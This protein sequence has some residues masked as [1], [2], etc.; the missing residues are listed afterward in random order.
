VSDADRAASE[1]DHRPDTAARSDDPLLKRLRDGRWVAR[2]IRHDFCLVAL[3]VVVGIGLAVARH[4]ELA[5]VTR[6]PTMQVALALAPIV[7]LLALST[8][9]SAVLA[10]W[11]GY[12]S[13]VGRLTQTIVAV[14]GLGFLWQLHVLGLL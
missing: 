8:A 7:A 9:V 4:G 1:Y 3:A 5:L 13:V 2:G 12:W 11:R 6:P 10:W 14:L